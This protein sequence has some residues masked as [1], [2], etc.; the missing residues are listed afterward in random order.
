MAD[1]LTRSTR[2]SVA[3]V[4]LALPCFVLVFSIPLLVTGM[5]AERI[6]IPFR[7]SSMAPH[8]P[9]PPFTYMLVED[10]V[11]VDGGGCRAF[12]EAW[13]A[14]YEASAEMRSLLCGL[15]LLWGSSGCLISGALIVVAATTSDDVGFGLCFTVPWLWASIGGLITIHWV[16][17]ALAHERRVWQEDNGVRVE[18]VTSVDVEAI[19]RGE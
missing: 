1:N 17:K 6:R 18:E 4:D 15:S 2:A 3:V 19:G 5:Y 14:R 9:L 7:L 11:A 10:V 8:T 16:R 12:R 13:R